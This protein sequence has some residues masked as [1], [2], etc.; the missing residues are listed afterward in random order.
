EAAVFFVHQGTPVILSEDGTRLVRPDGSD[1]P[2]DWYD[3]VS[4]FV[5]LARRTGLSLTDLD[6]VLRTCCDNRLD[7]AALRTVA[8]VLDLRDR[9]DLSVAVVCSLAAPMDTLG[10]DATTDPTQAP[11]FVRVFDPPTPGVVTPV[12]RPVPGTAPAGQTELICTGD[13]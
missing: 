2:L 5:R 12:I 9:L 13:L 7:G 1:I 3:R 10:L 8:V 4:R 11:L 6:L